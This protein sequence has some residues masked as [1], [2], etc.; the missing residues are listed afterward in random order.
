MKL[1][2]PLSRIS[3]GVLRM[4][5]GDKALFHRVTWRKVVGAMFDNEK[6]ESESIWVSGFRHIKISPMILRA[7]TQ[8]NVIEIQEWIGKTAV[9]RLTPLGRELANEKTGS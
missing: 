1:T 5:R 4:M 6:I 8:R 7:L 9:Y 2:T 3:A